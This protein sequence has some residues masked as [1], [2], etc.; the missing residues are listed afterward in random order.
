MKI[1]YFGTP[2]HSA[3]LLNSLYENGFEIA[4]VVTNIDKPQ[5]RDRKIS[6]SPV[7][8]LALEHSTS[9]LQFPS[10]KEDSAIQEINSFNADI[11]IVYAFGS[12]IPRKIFDFPRGKTINLHGS[13]LPEFRGASPIQ[14]AILSDYKE[15]GITLQYITDELDAGSILSIA[16]TQ[17]D[18]S[19]TF[20]TLLDRLTILG[21]T[22]LVK[23]LK[24]FSGNPYPS[25]QQDHSRAS[26]CK[27]IKVEDRKLD[28]SLTDIEVHNKVRAFNPGNI[29]FTTYREKRLNVYKTIKTDLISEEKA[30][31]LHILDKKSFGVV[32]GNKKI[33]I[34][35][36]VQ[37]E[38]KKVTKSIDFMNGSRPQ[39]GEIFT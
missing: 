24:T 5:G 34:L 23:L 12:I 4:F 39:N 35:D 1:G 29:C 17:I 32:C 19:D 26:F 22:E 14:A 27:K 38:N 11:Y 37:F 33:V 20:G 36:E 16:K 15:T 3:K 6:S 25:V 18:D 8:K 9:V 28:F 10:L 21:T 2:E 7:K 13:I 31:S 30:G